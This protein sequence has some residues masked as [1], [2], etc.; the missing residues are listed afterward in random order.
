MSAASSAV[1]PVPPQLAAQATASPPTFPSLRR[2][3]AT[4]SVST[5]VTTLSPSHGDRLEQG[6]LLA[7]ATYIDWAV[8][9]KRTWGLDVLVCPACHK[10]LRVMTTVIE[11]VVIRQI[12]DHLELPSKPSP[13]A[14]A[15]SAS[16]EQHPFDFDAA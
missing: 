11:P 10:R 15:R 5:D 7:K 16:W 9:M 14:P 4:P 8:L 6:A 12:L 2:R 3:D 13:R 1:Q